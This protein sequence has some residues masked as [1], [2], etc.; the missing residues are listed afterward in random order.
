MHGLQ[1]LQAFRLPARLNVE[2]AGALLGFH[3]DSIR[4]LVGIGLL[5][6]LG[7]SV[8][9][10]LMFATIYI[11]RICR[12]E[13]W[14][15]KATAAVQQHHRERNAAQIARRSGVGQ[16]RTEASKPHDR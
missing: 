13:K 6:S 2:E 15:R 5:N 14:L 8:D 12:D 7:K 16:A 1:V 3:P 9:V 4:F 10:Q 11:R